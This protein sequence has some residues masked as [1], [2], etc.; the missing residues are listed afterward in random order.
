[1]SLI[2]IGQRNTTGRLQWAL[3]ECSRSRSTFS[4]QKNWDHLLENAI[5]D[6]E[7]R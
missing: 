4:V 3:I 6:E 2:I 1:M 5:I 7:A